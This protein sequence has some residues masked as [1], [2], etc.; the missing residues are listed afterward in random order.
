MK[1]AVITANLGNFDPRIDYVEQSVKHDFYRFTDENFPPRHKAMTSRLQARI[2]KMFGWQMVPGY[3][4]YIWVDASCTLSSP[5]SVRWFIDQCDGVDMAVFKHPERSTIQQEADFLKER[6]KRG[7]PYIVS[8]Y[9][10][11]LIDEQMEVIKADKSFA[12]QNLFASTALVYKNNPKVHNV[13][14]H[15]WHHT[16]RYH[17]IDQLSLPYV[18]FTQNCKVRIIPDNYLKN[19][20]LMHVRKIKDQAPADN[21]KQDEPQKK[22]EIATQQVLAV[23]PVQQVPDVI[24]E[25]EQTKPVPEFTPEQEQIDSQGE[26]AFWRS[27]LEGNGKAYEQLRRLNHRFLR[28]ISDKR[29]V[30]IANLGAGPMNL[31][32]DDLRH[33]NVKVISSDLYANEYA[34]MLK[35]LNLHPANPVEKQ[36]MTALTYA[37]NSF[38]AVY[39]GNALDHTQS[40][41]KALNEMIRVCK[42]GGYVYLRHVVHEGKRD[43][44]RNLHRWYID[45]TENNDCVIW[46]EKP[47][48]EKNSFL[49]SE[50]YPGFTTTVESI[51]RGALITSIVQKK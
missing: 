31:I 35:E 7:D 16:S 11:E 45:R 43:N 12:D 42:P 30:M 48:L 3:D 24:K 46:S 39:C 10:N 15:W 38:D 50:V 28:L 13:M 14:F 1:I 18:L 2:V 26:L 22:T 47:G 21:T 37:D 41:L 33:I 19:P 29:E 27:W 44:H 34:A 51:P 40:P 25:T 17:S 36:D 49:L 20:Y 32:G 23:Q 5:D 9:E 4:Y 6:L 8:R